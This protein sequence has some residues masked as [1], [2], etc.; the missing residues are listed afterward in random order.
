MRDQMLRLTLMCGWSCISPRIIPMSAP[1]H[2]YLRHSGTLLTF[3]SPV[4][5]LAYA[6][7]ET[8]TVF[9]DD[10]TAIDAYEAK[11][12]QLERVV[13][14]PA[15]SRDVFARWADAYDRDHRSAPDA[16]RSSA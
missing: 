7:T 5:P 15:H 8:A 3:S 16:K 14:S 12:R 1:S 10:P 4:K 9:H 13:L 11:M 6:E 2:T